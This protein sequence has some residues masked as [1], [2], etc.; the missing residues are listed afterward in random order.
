MKVE[1][2]QQELQEQETPQ[3]QEGQQGQEGQQESQEQQAPPPAS[4]PFDDESR[5]GTVEG[6]VR[7]IV[8][9][10]GVTYVYNDWTKVNVDF[11]KLEYPA[12]IFIQPASGN[13]H[14][15]NGTIKDQPDTQ[16]AFMDKTVHDDEAVNEDCVVERMKRL[17]YRFI[18]AFNESRLFEPLPE[19]IPYRTVIDHL[20]QIVSGIII[21]PRIKEKKGVLL[22][23]IDIPHHE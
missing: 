23:N 21:T 3:E 18:R 17:C 6:K 5:L 11:D 9:P 10:L 7:S 16:F 15:A 19:D 22:C 8:E 13:F 4:V 1:N 14:V 20:D 12:I 2:E